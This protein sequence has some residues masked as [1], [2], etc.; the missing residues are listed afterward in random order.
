MDIVE[1]IARAQ[2]QG[3]PQPDPA[4]PSEV[5]TH[6]ATYYKAVGAQPPLLLSKLL[7]VAD[8][9]AINGLVIYGTQTR[10]APDGRDILGLE[11]AW[12]RFGPLQ[13]PNGN[14]LYAIG[15][16]DGVLLAH[17]P[18]DDAWLAIDRADGSVREQYR[19]FDEL[20]AARL[21]PSLAT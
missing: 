7:A 16:D 19:D 5:V 13:G 9:L 11:D 14:A 8:G 15:E 3:K 2:A 4:S 17:A 18:S 1:V 21:G 10:H 12:E 20:L 6:Q